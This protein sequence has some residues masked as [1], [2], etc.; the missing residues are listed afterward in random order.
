[1]NEELVLI[2]G[3]GH[4]RN[5]SYTLIYTKFTGKAEHEALAIDILR[6]E[7]ARINSNRRIVTE[8]HSLCHAV[9]PL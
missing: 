4:Y 8:P 3:S 5:G 9:R 7:R 1:M 2:E 6:A